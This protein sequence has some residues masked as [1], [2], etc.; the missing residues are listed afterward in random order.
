MTG[1][2]Q[3]A[4]PTVAPVPLIPYLAVDIAAAPEAVTFLRGVIVGFAEAHGASATVLGDV[5]RAVS[6][7]VGNV[8]VHAYGDGQ[9]GL[10]HV[11]ID[12]DDDALELVVADDGEGF[13][14]G[15]SSGLGLGLI[16]ITKSSADFAVRQR[17][18][19]GT[20]VWMRFFLDG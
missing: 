6:E 4:G 15:S 5:A 2:D 1:V 18:R 19:S 8:V 9:K 13:R 10:V 17:P 12:V 14:A 11:A 16:L 7:A 20:E 3:R